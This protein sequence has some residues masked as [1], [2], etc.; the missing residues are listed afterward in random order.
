ME[1]P[2]SA[3]Q[4]VLDAPS[5]AA[6]D[7]LKVELL[8]EFHLGWPIGDLLSLLQSH[9]GNAVQVG[10][11]I[12]SELGTNG[13]P[14]LIEIVPLLGHTAPTVRFLAIDCVLEWA[15]AT[16]KLALAT[17]ARL[18]DDPTMAVRWKVLQFLSLASTGQLQAA[19]S[20]LKSMNGPARLVSGLAWLLSEGAEDPLKVLEQLRNPDPLLR[21][22]GVVAA[23]RLWQRDEEPLI[24]ASKSSDSEV[25]QFAADMLSLS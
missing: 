9:N 8:D 2:P 7:E 4:R 16:D 22:F 25:R 20:Q 13:K 1:G 17:A 12:A 19:R 23:T 6:R 3:L 10:I 21:K 18:V 24:G 5:A 15:S 14:L 11:W